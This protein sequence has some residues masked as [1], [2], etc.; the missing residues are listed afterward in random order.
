MS[1]AINDKSCRFTKKP[2]ADEN[3]SQSGACEWEVEN[4]EPVEEWELQ[5]LLIEE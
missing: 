1:P 3:R 5:H 4:P 2:C